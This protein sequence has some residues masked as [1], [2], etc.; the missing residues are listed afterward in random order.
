MRS[1]GKKIKM[2][3]RAP[4]RGDPRAGFPLGRKIEVRYYEYTHEIFFCHFCVHK[5]LFV[6]FT[7]FSHK[8][9]KEVF[10]YV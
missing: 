2:L 4:E 8:C 5:T 3:R 1:I 6:H 10:Y 7:L 9:I